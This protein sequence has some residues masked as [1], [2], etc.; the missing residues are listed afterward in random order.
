[1]QSDVFRPDRART[2]ARPIDGNALAYVVAT[3]AS[4]RNAW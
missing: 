1:M 2:P 3:S 4:R